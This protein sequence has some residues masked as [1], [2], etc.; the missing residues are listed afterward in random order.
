VI[1][2]E[3]TSKGQPLHVL[4]HIVWRKIDRRGNVTE[5]LMPIPTMASEEHLLPEGVEDNQVV[6]AGQVFRGKPEVSL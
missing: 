3:K 6:G 4:T 1:G 5:A 2:P